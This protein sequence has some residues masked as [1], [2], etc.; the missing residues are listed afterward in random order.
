[1]LKPS[2]FTIAT[3]INNPEVAVYNTLTNAFA[4]M[5]RELWETYGSDGTWEA[6]PHVEDLTKY[7]FLVPANVDE[8]QTFLLNRNKVKFYSGHLTFTVLTTFACNL[9]CKYCMQAPVRLESDAGVGVVTE[10]VSALNTAEF[11]E[12]VVGEYRPTKLL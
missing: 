10:D 11:I 5:E 12:K 8:Y 9:A 1:M 7:G 4:I 2:Q 3:D 6:H